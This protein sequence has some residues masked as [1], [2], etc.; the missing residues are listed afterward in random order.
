MV[1]PWNRRTLALCGTLALVLLSACNGK[2]AAQSSAAPARKPVPQRV[3]VE[4]VERL[5]TRSSHRRNG[6][7]KASRTARLFNQEEGQVIEVP[8][9]EGEWVKRGDLLV[10]LDDRLLQAQLAKA[11]ATT[12]QARLDLKRLS[13]LVKRRAVSEEE[14]TRA[15]TAL[16][17]ALAEQK[18]LETR[19]DYTRLSAPFDGQISERRVEP[20]DVVSRYSHLMS[21][22][23]PRSLVAELSISELL[24]PQLGVGDPVTLRIDALGT[25]SYPGRILR[26]H[27]QL[28]PKTHQGVVE[29]APDPVPEG[30]RAGQ[31]VRV[32]FQTRERPRLMIPF[33]ALRRDRNGA[34]V[35]LMDGENRAHRQ[36]VRSGTRIAD[37]V[38][39]V[40]GLKAG[41]TL[42]TRG[43][44]GLTEGRS[45]EPINDRSSSVAGDGR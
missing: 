40:E 18:L 42:I 5:P 16:D 8:P 44:L 34:F 12:R 36:R 24:L 43:F 26:I 31:F 2:P 15:S 14:L 4:L 28:D 27:P 20:G 13:D 30:A 19:I 11:R 32:T 39:I 33:H 37:R 6:T 7:L 41:D 29:V 38:E 35:Y 25:Q 17:V 22:I 23:D 45:V 10:R 9:H 21:M 1:S 3:E